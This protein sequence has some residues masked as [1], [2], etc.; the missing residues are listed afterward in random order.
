M[1]IIRQ[2][3]IIA[4]I[5]ILSELLRVALHLPIPANVLGMVLLFLLLCTGLIKE[6]DI[7]EVADF[8]YEHMAFFLIPPTCGIVVEAG[9][10]A[11]GAISFIVVAALSTLVVYLITGHSVQLFQRLAARRAPLKHLEEER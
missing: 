8:F 1:K 11:D 7:K 2:L 10:L 3:G 4:C 9:A 6:S 5:L